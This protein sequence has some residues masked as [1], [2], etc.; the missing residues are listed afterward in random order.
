MG[1]CL[2]IAAAGY[3]DAPKR[4]QEMVGEPL[5]PFF[6]LSFSLTPPLFPFVRQP[7]AVPSS[8]QSYFLIFFDL[9][10]PLVYP[11]AFPRKRGAKQSGRTGEGR[12]EGRK[13]RELNKHVTASGGKEEADIM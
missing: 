1:K 4:E 8:L 7:V 3:M 6:A 5:Y 11:R 13:A 12:F 10:P 9:D 2:F